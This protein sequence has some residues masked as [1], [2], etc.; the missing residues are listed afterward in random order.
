MKSFSAVVIAISLFLIILTSPPP[1]HPDSA[2][3]IDRTSAHWVNPDGTRG[4]MM[5]AGE[6]PASPRRQY[7]WIN[8]DGVSGTDQGHLDRSLAKDY[9]WVNPDGAAGKISSAHA[10][11]DRADPAF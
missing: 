10:R 11:A 4:L 6:P 1:S 9:S 7:T 8:P 3:S 2:G 5:G